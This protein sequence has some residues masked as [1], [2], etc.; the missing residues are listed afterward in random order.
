MYTSG[1]TFS[2]GL[3]RG[4][5]QE[6]DDRCMLVSKIM[7]LSLT[8]LHEG[9]PLH[10]AAVCR[11]A[12]DGLESV[13]QRTSVPS[14]LAAFE[15]KRYNSQLMEAKTQGMLGNTAAE[16]Q[17]QTHYKLRSDTFISRRHFV[18]APGAA[19]IFWDIYGRDRGREREKACRGHRAVS[20]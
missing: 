2:K 11:A 9:G 6:H 10:H 5:Q 19:G 1:L 18:P 17:R 14:R 7:E 4:V 3:K 12:R 15:D 20:V 16:M 8:H 13:R